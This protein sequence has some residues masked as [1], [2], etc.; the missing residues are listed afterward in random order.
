MKMKM[1]MKM[2]AA[3]LAAVFTAFVALPAQAQST[4]T[5]ISTSVNARAGLSPILSVTCD[6]VNFG[7]WRVPIRNSGGTTAITL[8]VSANDATGVSS[9]TASGNT[10]NVAL[11][12]GYL[13]PSAATCNVYGSRPVGT[14]LT[15]AIT[16]NTTLRFIASNHESLPT[17]SVMADLTANLALAAPGVAVDANGN[18]A[19]RVVGVLTIPQPIVAGNYG[20]YQ[21]GTGTTVGGATVSFTDVR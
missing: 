12:T 2:N 4:S 6:A 14:T 3:L 20:G 5:T 21:T 17:P 9:G 10:I 16:G 15:T 7:V 11:D 13:L 19:F 1:K 18:G 8:T